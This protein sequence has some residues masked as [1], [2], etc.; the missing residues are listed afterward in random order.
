[1]LFRQMAEEFAPGNIKLLPEQKAMAIGNIK[2]HLPSIMSTLFAFLGHQY[3]FVTNNSFT[4]ENAGKLTLLTLRMYSTKLLSLYIKIYIF[5]SEALLQFLGWVPLNEVLNPQYM[6]ILF[7]F[8]H[9]HNDESSLLAFECVNEILGQNFV[10]KA[11]DEFMISIFGQLF[12][13]LQQLTQSKDGLDQF[14][15]EY[16]DKFTQFTS[17]FV[18]KHL[19][20][21]EQKEGFPIIEFLS[22]LFQ[23]TFMQTS[24][25][26]FLSCIEIW[27]TFLD[28]IISQ[29]EGTQPSSLHLGYANGLSALGQQLVIKIQYKTNSSLL[30]TLD[31]ESTS[32][33]E[34]DS[35]L[36]M[37][38]D[39]SLNI[40]GK[41]AQLY[42]EQILT[43]LSPLLDRANELLQVHTQLASGAPSILH[44][45]K[46]AEILLRIFSQAACG[47]VSKL[48]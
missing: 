47:F 4:N 7:Q 1:M 35:E 26:G 25:E 21:V 13:L 42:P 6:D 37:Y 2:Q 27:E 41:I 15:E 3:S 44:T 8:I 38:L 9:L 36:E 11:F 28:Y 20:R 29:Q 31:T 43:V 19:R 30:E 14:Q 23:F 48:F 24:L 39:A 17:L 40:I 33:E 32:E 12:K 45:I 18:L 22:L 5:W 34:N 10:P 16:V 46:D